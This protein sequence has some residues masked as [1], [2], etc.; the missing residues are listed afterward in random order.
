SI[1][2]QGDF[3]A[4]AL[5]TDAS[6]AGLGRFSTAP[7]GNITYTNGK[8]AYIWAGEEM[9]VGGVFFVQDTSNTNPIDYTEELNN[10]LDD[11]DNIA[12]LGVSDEKVTNGSMEAD[13]NWSDLM[14]AASPK[15]KAV[16]IAV[17]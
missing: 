12:N 1:P 7:Q 17:R 16:L 10:T 4:T 11:S 2:S 13:A 6:G 5:H 14:S 8:E 3:E 9:R 15:L